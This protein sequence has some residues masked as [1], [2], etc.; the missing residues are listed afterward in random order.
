RHAGAEQPERMGAAAV[1]GRDGG[2]LPLQGRHDAG[3]GRLLGRRYRAV[4]CRIGVAMK[5][6]LPALIVGGT[7]MVGAAL[8][9]TATTIDIAAMPAGETPPGFTTWRTGQG[10]AAEWRVIADPTAAGG[11]AIAQT[12]KDK[13]DYR[14]PLAV[15]QPVS[16]KNVEVT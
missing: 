10:E 5:R 9:Q 12:S 7:L 15:Y 2:D 8:A 13:T 6:L 3:A 14:F 11:K 4:P 1:A 16:A